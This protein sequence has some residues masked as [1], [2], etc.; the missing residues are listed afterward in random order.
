MRFAA[1][2]LLPL[3]ACSGPTELVPVPII[4]LEERVGTRF[5][6]IEV[7]EVSLP[8]YAASDEILEEVEGALIVSDLFWADDPIRSMTLALARNLKELTGA[9]VAPEP[10]PFDSR[11]AARVDVRVEALLVQGEALVFSGQYFVADQEDRGRNH[12]HLFELSAQILG[13]TPE[14]VAAARAQVVAD[15][16]RAIAS[17]AL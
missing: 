6:S 15:L 13:A 9:R 11:A 16:A 5:A 8:A 1:L 10:W 2:L 4:A 7:A 12:A 14:T 3:A 17:S